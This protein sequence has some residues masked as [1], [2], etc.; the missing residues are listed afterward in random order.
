MVMSSVETDGRVHP[1]CINASNP[2]H[3]C[4]EYCF[5]RIAQAQQQPLDAT[6][7]DGNERA[8][9]LFCYFLCSAV[10]SFLAVGIHTVFVC[11]RGW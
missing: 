10:S 9:P 5:R 6:T 1:A 8:S 11:M 2:F 4:S 3:E 7:S